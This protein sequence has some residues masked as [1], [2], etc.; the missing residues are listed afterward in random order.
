MT[1]TLGDWRSRWSCGEIGP[2]VTQMKAL[3]PFSCRVFE[4]LQPA[5]ISVLFSSIHKGC[6]CNIAEGSVAKSLNHSIGRCEDYLVSLGFVGQIQRAR[7]KRPFDAAASATD[8]A[9]VFDK[10]A[11]SLSAFVALG[12][13]WSRCTPTLLGL[14]EGRA[15]VGIELM[16]RH[17]LVALERAAEYSIRIFVVEV[18]RMVWPAPPQGR[19][20][21]PF[22]VTAAGIVDLAPLHPGDFM[23]DA[24]KTQQKWVRSLGFPSDQVDI[25]FAF[26]DRVCCQRHLGCGALRRQLVHHI[27]ADLD[28]MFFGMAAHE[29]PKSGDY[30]LLQGAVSVLDSQE[31]IKRLATYHLQAR[32]MMQPPP[33]FV[34]L[35]TDKSSVKSFQLMN[36]MVALPTS[37]SCW[38]CPQVGLV[39][40][41]PV[42]HRSSGHI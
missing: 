1:S 2:C 8:E 33:L 35:A 32:A 9:P 38:L 36:T 42:A 30:L 4:A 16:L 27:G 21:L 26:C 15:R 25:F 22:R 41:A 20:P 3:A 10:A 39:H 34:S 17:M 37:R 14:C 24:G 31:T 13:A 5:R 7:A 40:T 6:G 12:V 29:P 23:T 11:C 28:S 19:C 18:C